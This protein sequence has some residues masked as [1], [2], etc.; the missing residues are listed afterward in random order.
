MDSQQAQ[1]DS[2]S[3]HGYSDLGNYGSGTSAR[4][5]GTIFRVNSVNNKTDDHEDY[6]PR[7]SGRDVSKLGLDGP[8]HI[9]WRVVISERWMQIHMFQP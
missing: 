8:N 6:D 2:N 4:R 9:E 3:S 5:A 7:V 1:E